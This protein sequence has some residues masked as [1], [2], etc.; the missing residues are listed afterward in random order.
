MQ[1]FV[2]PCAWSFQQPNSHI[3]HRCFN[4]LLSLNQSP[5]MNKVAWIVLVTKPISI[6]IFYIEWPYVVC[7]YGWF[8]RSELA[9][10]HARSSG[11]DQMDLSQTPSITVC[12]RSTTRVILYF[13]FETKTYFFLQLIQISFLPLCPLPSMLLTRNVHCM[14][15]QL[16]NDGQERTVQLEKSCYEW[17]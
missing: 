10:W 15:K 2:T 16:L 14:L 9:Y 13:R 4:V 1:G 11:S 7:V 12:E 6:S 8:E 3:Y 17:W 5:R